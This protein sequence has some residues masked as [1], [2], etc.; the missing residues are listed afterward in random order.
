[1]PQISQSK[2][3]SLV[4]RRYPHGRSTMSLCGYTLKVQPDA[5]RS[6]V[7]VSFQ[8][9]GCYM[10]GLAIPFAGCRETSALDPTAAIVVT[11]VP[12]RTVTCSR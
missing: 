2:R 8:E 7:S 9:R 11:D 12:L 3:N 1:V 5:L 6:A 10:T 4:R